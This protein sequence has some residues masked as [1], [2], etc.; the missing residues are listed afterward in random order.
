MCFAIYSALIMRETFS[1]WHA[2]GLT[3]ALGGIIGIVLS[4]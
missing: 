2:V 3:A 1:R 4:G